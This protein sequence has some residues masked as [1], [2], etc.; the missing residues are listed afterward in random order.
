MT[1]ME[2]LQENHAATAPQH[3]VEC[4]VWRRPLYAFVRGGIVCK[5]RSCKDTAHFTSKEEAL[6]IWEALESE[7]GQ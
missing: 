4:P 1:D 6:Q 2:R 7:G 3:R 5:C